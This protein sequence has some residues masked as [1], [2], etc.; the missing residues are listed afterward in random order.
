MGWQVL[1]VVMVAICVANGDPIKIH[2]LAFEL[3]YAFK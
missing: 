2:A 1:F 3:K